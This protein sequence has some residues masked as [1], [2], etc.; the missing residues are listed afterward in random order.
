MADIQTTYLGLKLQ[1]PLIISSGP[2]TNR[3]DR[4]AELE[5][6]GV[7]AIVMRSIF[8]EQIT[9]EIADM[10]SDLENET[11]AFAMDYLRADLPA[12]LGP[13]SY[14]KKIEDAKKR[15]EIPIIASCNC[16]NKDKW[17]S[18][19][20]KIEQAGADALELN[21]YHMP[22]DPNEDSARVEARNIDLIQ[23]VHDELKI[24][25]DVKLSYHYTALLPYARKL[26]AI[27]I[28]GLVLFNRFLQTDVDVENETTF[29]TPNYST[30]RVLHTQ[31]RWTAILRDWIKAD[32][33]ISGGIHS[34][35]DL[36]KALL[37]G[38]NVGYIYSLLQLSSNH[39]R[40]VQQILTRLESWMR[41]KN[42]AGLRDFRGK[43]RE[44][45]L[46]DGKG[47]E[48][49]QYVKAATSVQ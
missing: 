11:S 6:A 3:V 5:D 46:H 36:I 22:I 1:N 2:L 7:S 31:L 14:L 43:L 27:G 13:E 8:E 24:P 26:D 48:R 12:Q 32:I 25:V 15:V 28:A 47:F 10:Y 18:Y 40:T 45:N 29:Y 38:A 20:K 37:V 41:D 39:K 9:A 30:S 17:I 34:G 35:D 33:A 42:Y 23:A 21:L 16:L 49:A 44:T 4:M 19:A